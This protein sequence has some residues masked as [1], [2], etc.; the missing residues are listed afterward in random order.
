MPLVVIVSVTTSF[1]AWTYDQVV[2]LPAI[3]E[4]AIRIREWP[5]PWYASWAVRVYILINGGHMFQRFFIAD[6]LW[7]FWLAPSFLVTT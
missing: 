2:F 5:I 4:A 1:F 7:Y 3:I 6:E